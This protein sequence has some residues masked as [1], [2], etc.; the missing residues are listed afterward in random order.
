VRE[1]Q[2]RARWKTTAISVTRRPSRL[3]GAQVERHARPPPGVDVDAQRGVGLGVAAAVDA[4][5]VAVAG[6]EYAALPPLAYVPNA[7]AESR[8]AGSRTALSALS[9]STRSDWASKETGSSIAV[10]ASSCSRWFCITSRQAPM[11]S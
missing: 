1:R 5:L 4:L 8:S 10:S 6:D 2:V 7:D 9:F 3:P 11:P